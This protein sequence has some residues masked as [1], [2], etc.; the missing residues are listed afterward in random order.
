MI[1]QR[2]LRERV[3]SRALRWGRGAKGGLRSLDLSA[4]TL[5]KGFEITL[6]LFLGDS[7]GS[8]LRGDPGGKLQVELA[9][10]SHR[11]STR[12]TQ[13]HELR[14]ASAWRRRAVASVA[15]STPR[16][17]TAR[18]RRAGSRSTERR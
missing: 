14:T 11:K 3:L 8:E 15:D 7:L 18:L 5:L 16:V 1:A 9:P 17:R 6:D 13:R 12:I 10:N 2:A 4:A